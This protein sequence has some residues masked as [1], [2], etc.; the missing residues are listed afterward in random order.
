M[1]VRNGAAH[2]ADQLAALSVQSY[3]GDWEVVIVDNGSTDGT[4]SVIRRWTTRL[5]RLRVLDASRRR[6]INYAR[7]AGAA[8]AGGELLA[9]CDADDVADELWLHHLVLAAPAADIVGGAFDRDA[10]N[11]EVTRRWCPV[12]D[13]PNFEL[14][15]RFLPAVP[16]GNCA[17]WRDVALAVGWDESFRFG[18]SDIEFCWRAQLASYGVTQEPR[19][20]MRLRYRRSLRR[21]AGQHFARGLAEPQL[22]RAFRSAGMPGPGL[23]E[24]ASAGR[25]LI[26]QRP[27][28][29]SASADPGNWLRV[30]AL[31]AGRAVGCV[32]RRTLYLERPVPAFA[33]VDGARGIGTP[34][35]NGLAPS[36]GRE[37]G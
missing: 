1:P 8:A 25:W 31:A 35:V 14:G 33:L 36:V 13:L 4:I 34:A 27:G 5:P 32:R 15:Y 2:I 21:L 23:S 26:A 11:G 22:Y 9:F 20:I 17:V 30:A 19:A 10:L 6:G 24:A 3:A 12:V 37:A 7:N 29:R 16:G 18:S 28:A